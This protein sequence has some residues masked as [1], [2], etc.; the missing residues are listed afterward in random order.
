MLL[1]PL[2]VTVAFVTLALPVADTPL[3]LWR[4]FTVTFPPDT[5]AAAVEYIP[6]KPSS[7]ATPV[8]EIFPA[9]W[10]TP[11]PCIPALLL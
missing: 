6:C 7:P 9:V 2:T 8:K 4:P 10:V 3:L 11:F 5:V 1:L